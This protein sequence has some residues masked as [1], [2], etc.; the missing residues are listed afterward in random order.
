M[1]ILLVGHRGY[2]G[3]V[4]ATHLTRALPGI[5]VHGIDA[6]WFTGSEAAPFPDPVFASQR[7]AD[8]RDLTEADFKG[9]DAVVAL[10]AVSNDPIGKEFEDATAD[11]NSAAV[12][13]AARAA[14]AA[15]VRR[16]VFASSCSM[17]GAGSDSLRKET[18]TLNPLTAY[19]KSK[20]ATEEGLRGL[21]TDE[22][23]ITSLRFATACGASPMLRL[24]LVLNDFVATALRTGKIEVLSD[25]SPWRPLIHVEDMSRA[26]EWA[27]TRAGDSMVEVNVGSQAWTWQ[28]GQLAREVAELLGGVAVEINTNAA[29]DKRSYRVDFARFAAL[30]P[31]HQPQKD[32]ATAVRELAEEVRAIDFGAEAI[33]ESRFIRLNVLRG[34]VQNGKLD[35]ELRWTSA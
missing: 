6:N 26:I 23:M 22:F 17:Y 12:L 29:P 35:G 30:A 31:N 5:A 21:A 13:K 4:V 34:L 25:G 27:V 11:I 14:R 28:V 2:I 16:F 24:D 19:A 8:V 7:R 33:R 32:F 20:V 18:D 10:A 15:G 1:N 3:P 9:M